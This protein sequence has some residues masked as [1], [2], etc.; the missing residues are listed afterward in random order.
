M[1]LLIV[2]LAL[3]LAAPAGAMTL[4]GVPPGGAGAAL[5]YVVGT[6]TPVK[7]LPCATVLYSGAGNTQYIDFEVKGGAAGTDGCMVYASDSCSTITNPIP[8][9]ATGVGYW[10]PSGGAQWDHQPINYPSAP[11]NSANAL[12][13]SWWA[14]CSQTGMLVGVTTL[15]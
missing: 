2:L 1:R 10:L 3:A 4:N 7:V 8:N 12:T 13:T 14:V 5:P 9:P 6:A 11:G 15:P